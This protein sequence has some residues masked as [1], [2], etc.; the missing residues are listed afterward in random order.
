MALSGKAVGAGIVGIGLIFGA[1]LWYATTLAWYDE[2]EGVEAIEV[3][4]QRFAVSGYRGLD[5]RTSPLKLRG[6]FT[7]DDPEGALAAGEAADDA[8]PITTPGWFD[9]YDPAMILAGM[10]AGE[11]EAVMAGRDEGDGAD[12]Y[13]AV[14]EDGRGWVWRQP[15]GKYERGGEGLR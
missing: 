6:C 13:L 7:L 10:E 8:V 9:C 14:H 3:N 2:V 15:N 12:L 4:G 1:G 5:G 11:I